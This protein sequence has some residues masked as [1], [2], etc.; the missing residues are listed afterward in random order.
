MR[1]ICDK[2][3]W[4][5]FR[6]KNSLSTTFPEFFPR[7]PWLG[8]PSVPGYIRFISYVAIWKG[9]ISLSLK[10][11]GFFFR[12]LTDSLITESV[13]FKAKKTVFERK[14]CVAIATSDIGLEREKETARERQRGWRFGGGGD[15]NYPMAAWLFVYTCQCLSTLPFKKSKKI[16]AHIKITPTP[17]RRWRFRKW[18][19]FLSRANLCV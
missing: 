17:N 12:R 1:E 13:L 6:G 14:V 8:R 4:S 9:R 19:L 2:I 7:L 15:Q 18:H 3:P 10:I 16:I 5:C 11:L